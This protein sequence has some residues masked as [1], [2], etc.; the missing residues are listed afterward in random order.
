MKWLLVSSLLV[1]GLLA[2]INAQCPPNEHFEQCGT[3]CPRNCQNIRRPPGPCITAC[4]R[5]CFCNN[6]LVREFSGRGARCIP[7]NRCP[8]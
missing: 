8:R 4:R 5:G 3:A 7:P 2:S 1:F 6:N